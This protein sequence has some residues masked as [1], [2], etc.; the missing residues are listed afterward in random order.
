M[1][2]PM[3]PVMRARLEAAS[4]YVLTERRNGVPAGQIIAGLVDQYRA[5]F[6]RGD[7]N[8]LRCAGVTASCTHSDGQA[9]VDRWSGNATVRIAMENQHGEA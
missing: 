9:L 2:A 1:G 8:I 7:P 3:T 5:T 6:R 4:D